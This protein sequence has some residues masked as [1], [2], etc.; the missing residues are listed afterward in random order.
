M[1]RRQK[2]QAPQAVWKVPSTRSPTLTPVT[3]SP[4]AAT[5]PTYS[6]PIVKPGSIW[7]RPGSWNVTAS[8]AGLL[9]GPAAQQRR[10]PVALLP[11]RVEHGDDV[12]GADRAPPL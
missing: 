12:V 3:A 4:A 1:P 10:H 5:V 11:Q 6:C 7:T 8:I 2:K 9:Y